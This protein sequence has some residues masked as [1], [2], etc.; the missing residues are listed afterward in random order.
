MSCPSCLVGQKIKLSLTEE[1]VAKL[2]MI[3][4]EASEKAKAV[5]T[6]EQ[7]A[8]VTTAGCG[9][10]SMCEGGVCKL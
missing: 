7:A 1:Q 9:C 5:L 4:K 3:A 10:G 6:E 8:K 2:E